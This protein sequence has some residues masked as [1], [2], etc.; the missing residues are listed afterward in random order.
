MLFFLD[1]ILFRYTSNVLEA[2]MRIS[3][4]NCFASVITDFCWNRQFVEVYGN[5]D[6]LIQPN[7]GAMSSPE[8]STQ[9]QIS[10]AEFE[11]TNTT[12]FSDITQS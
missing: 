3:N 12:R 7:T 10:C 1:N 9:S 6:S 5:E 11:P 4:E 8:D 2:V